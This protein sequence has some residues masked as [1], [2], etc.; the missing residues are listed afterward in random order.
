MGVEDDVAEALIPPGLSAELKWR[1]AMSLSVAG[2]ILWVVWAM[3]F[4]FGVPGLARAGDVSDVKS[5]LAEVR[6]SLIAK[7]ID[8]VSTSLC[9]DKYDSNLINYRN[10]LQK[11]YKDLT[12]QYHESPP[13][14]VL[15]KLVQH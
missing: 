2:I 13:C 12:G 14:E 5:Q 6:A 4:L 1:L 11:T 10:A 3:G 9:M 8:N 7:D 15:T